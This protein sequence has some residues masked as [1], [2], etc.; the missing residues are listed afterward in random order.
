MKTNAWPTRN[1]TDKTKIVFFGNFQQ[2]F[3]I[4]NACIPSKKKLLSFGRRGIERKNLRNRLLSV[5]I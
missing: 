5:I 3:I 2:V 1:G 4:S